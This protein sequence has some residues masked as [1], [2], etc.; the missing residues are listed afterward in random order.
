MVEAGGDGG[1]LP[2]LPHSKELSNSPAVNHA[3]GVG[4]HAG[5]GKPG[6]R[7]SLNA[8]KKSANGLPMLATA[9]GSS[10]KTP[11]TPPKTPKAGGAGHGHSQQTRLSLADREVIKEARRKLKAIASG[12]HR[13]QEGQAAQS[14]GEGSCPPSNRTLSRNASKSFI[15]RH[16]EDEDE[17]K[18]GDE[19]KDE[20]GLSPQLAEPTESELLNVA[21]K[22]GMYRTEEAVPDVTAHARAPKIKKSSASL[23]SPS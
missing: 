23:T 10:P 3:G 9:H 4:R 8:P 19:L 11:K 6:L 22:M 1:G 20:D 17:S 5:R 14:P 12:R 16:E 2:A 15:F 13:Q 18:T 7:A 21:A